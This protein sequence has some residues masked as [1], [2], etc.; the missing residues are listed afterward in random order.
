M[1]SFI[2]EPFHTHEGE[3]MDTCISIAKGIYI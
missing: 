1:Y 2:G 3:K